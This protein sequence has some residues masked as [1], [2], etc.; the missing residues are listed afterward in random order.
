A[1]GKRKQVF[2]RLAVRVFGK[3]RFAGIVQS[4]A[5]EMHALGYK[6][7]TTRILLLT[8]APLLLSVRSPHIEDLTLDLLVAFQRDVERVAVEKCLIAIS[9]VLA[10]RGIIETPLRRL[11]PPRWMDG[12]PQVLLENVPAEWS[13]LARHWHDTSTLSPIARLRHYYRLLCVGR[14]LSATHPE[15]TGPA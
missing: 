8:L 14:W 6:P 1:F 11:G 3:A 4:L 7:R 10:A 2:F 12:D 5:S 15:I 9:R 13:R